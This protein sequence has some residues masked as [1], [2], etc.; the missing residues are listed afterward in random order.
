[1]TVAR[2]AFLRAERILRV[3]RI[4]TT[5]F[6]RQTVFAIDR[7]HRCEDDVRRFPSATSWG[8][9]AAFASRPDCLA[10]NV[11]ML[12]RGSGD[13][14]YGRADQACVAMA[15]RLPPLDSIAKA[16]PKLSALSD[17]CGLKCFLRYADCICHESEGQ[18]FGW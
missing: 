14:H 7:G 16:G 6:G 13:G 4:A 3:P 15:P 5:C 1:M 2:Q 18:I 9:D 11:R 8:D 12:S 10:A 17:E